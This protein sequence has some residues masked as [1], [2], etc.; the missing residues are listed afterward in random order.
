MGLQAIDQKH[1]MSLRP[2]SMTLYQVIKLLTHNERTTMSS[3]FAGM[4]D[5][6]FPKDYEER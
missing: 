6:H 3:G 1:Q 4:K 5:D 2:G